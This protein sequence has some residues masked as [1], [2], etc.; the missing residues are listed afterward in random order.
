MSEKDL[1][2]ESV[3]PDG[4]VANT[5]LLLLLSKIPATTIR[6]IGKD[7]ETYGQIFQGCADEKRES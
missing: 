1:V 4:I 3:L 5:V 2:N 6:E 7:L